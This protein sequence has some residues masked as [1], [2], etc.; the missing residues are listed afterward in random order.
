MTKRKGTGPA[1]AQ[2]YMDH[3]AD[4]V[5][6]LRHTKRMDQATLAKAVGCSPATISNL[7][8]KKLGN[9]HIDHLVA[10]ARVLSTS[11]DDLLGLKSEDEEEPAQGVT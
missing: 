1:T 2:G 6:I 7:E 8:T 10:L 9:I 5:Y 4:R 3:L 11:T